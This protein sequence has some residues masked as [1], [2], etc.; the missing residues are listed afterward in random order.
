MCARHRDD[1]GQ[2][3][4]IERR[5]PP[6]PGR[7]GKYRN[8][9]HE[10]QGCCRSQRAGRGTPTSPDQVDQNSQ[11]REGGCMNHAFPENCRCHVHDRFPPFRKN[12]SSSDR[13]LAESARCSISRTSKS[14][15]EPRKTRSITSPR[16]FL[17]TSSYDCEGLYEN[18]RSWFVCTRNPLSARMRTRVATVV[19][20][21][22]NPAEASA[23]R[24]SATVDSPRFQNSCIT[25]SSRSVSSFAAGRAMNPPLS[26][27]QDHEIWF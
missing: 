1:R 21:R 7:K 4:D 12:S 27:L 8:E 19:Y 24:T 16:S 3:T 2:P 25:S 22:S 6:G 15:R 13:S 20:A 14:S 17:E 10:H 23:S 5:T 11:E 9:G 18:G 26:L